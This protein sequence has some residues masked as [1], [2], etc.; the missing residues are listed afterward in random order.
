MKGACKEC[1]SFLL[2]KIGEAES[3]RDYWNKKLIH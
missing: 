3:E 1:S 2:D